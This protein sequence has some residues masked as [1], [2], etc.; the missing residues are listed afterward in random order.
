MLMMHVNHATWVTAI[1]GATHIHSP[2]DHGWKQSSTQQQDQQHPCP[3]WLP[4]MYNYHHPQAP[5]TGA[6]ST[7][8]N[9]S[10]WKHICHSSVGP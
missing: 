5:P 1:T 3:H 10:C 9:A 7:T 8:S 2:T 4:G 6:Q